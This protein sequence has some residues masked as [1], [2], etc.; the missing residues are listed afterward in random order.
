MRY[1]VAKT[2]SFPPE[3]V[4]GLAAGALAVVLLS[5]V[6]LLVLRHKSSQAEREYKRIQLQMD[7]LEK[8]VRIECKQ[9]FAELQ[10]VVTDL[11]N[12]LQSA[13]IPTLDHRSYIMKVFFPGVYDH[14][15]LQD[16]KLKNNGIYSN[17]EVAMS[18]FE[19]LIL[20]KSFLVTFINTL[21][22]Q[23]SFTIRDRVNV[24]SLLMIIFMGRLEYGTDVL[25]TLLLQ[26]IERSVSS[27]HPQLMLRRTESVVEKML[28]NWLALS[29]YDYL[30]DYAGSSLFLL[31]SA[32]RHQVEKGPV[33]AVTYDARYSL[34]EARLLREQIDY[35]IVT[36]QVLQEDQDEKIHCKVNDCDTISQVKSKILDTLYKNTPFSLRPS[37]HDVDLEW[38]NGRSGHLIL[39]DEDMTTKTVNGWRQINTLRH[40]NVK[41]SAVMSLVMKQ[42][43]SFSSNCNVSLNSMSPI[44]SSHCELEHGIKYW[45]LVKPE[46]ET[47][48]QPKDIYHKAIPEIFLTRLLSTKGTVEKF[49]EDFLRTILT[50]NEA[51]P[52]AIKWLFDLLDE[53]AHRYG[54]IDPEVPHAWKSNCLPLR[55]WVNFIK[56]PDFILDVQKTPIVDSCLSVIAQTLMDACS[57]SEHR[58]GKDSPSNKLLFARDI[59]RYRR[60]VL[61][62]YQGI[63]MQPK[64]TDQEM[65]AAMQ[66]LSLAHSSEFETSGAVKE[67]YVYAAKYREQ[68]LMGLE[69]DLHCRKLHL[70]HKLLNVACTLEGEQ[71]SMC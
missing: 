6:I 21:E 4:A 53:A 51:L 11:T 70:S 29:M 26:L 71:T 57:T 1:E 10:T 42:N 56:N 48:G 35:D 49:V 63:A 43:D 27:K 30:R 32:I 38:R 61:D 28:T 24:A 58:L 9:A 17:Y 41:D 18:Q 60:K 2:Y 34:F 20:N 55:F 62:F 69:G 59:P 54:I 45:H 47:I 14:P 5:A 36:I 65:C 15:L 7:D 12:D 31:F 22:G 16:N 52:P 8:S 67:L 64:V 68:V 13:G 66:A 25:R 19:Q 50:V 40:Y 44:V 46:D 3:A 37:I 39:A 33:D 23:K